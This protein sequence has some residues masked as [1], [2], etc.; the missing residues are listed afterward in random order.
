[1][2]LVRE[3][4]LSAAQ[5][6][7]D[8]H[9]NVLRKWVKKSPPETHPALRTAMPPANHAV[10]RDEAKLHVVSFAKKAVAF[11]RMSRSA[12]RRMTSRRSRSIRYSGFISP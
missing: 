9:E 2:K 11:F 7:R 10:L 5:A 12:F 6:A 1:M 3:R 8:L 4:G